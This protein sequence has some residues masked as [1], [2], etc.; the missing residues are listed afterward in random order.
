MEGEGGGEGGREGGKEGQGEGGRGGERWKE[1]EG[2]EGMGGERNAEREREHVFDFLVA[3]PTTA[4]LVAELV[5]P[6]T[7]GGRD[8]YIE[9]AETDMLW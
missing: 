4:A 5:S 1:R 7:P 6:R 8:R 3:T 9:M 2:E